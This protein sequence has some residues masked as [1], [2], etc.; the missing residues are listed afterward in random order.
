MTE[1][2]S[3]RLRVPGLGKD[4]TELPLAARA[5]IATAVLVLVGGIAAPSTV[6]VAAILSTLPYFAILA[7]A[8][9]GQHLGRHHVVRCRCCYQ[10]SRFVH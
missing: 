6:S 9:I 5:L 4:L 1:Q 7:V 3:I 10:A 8:S 2:N